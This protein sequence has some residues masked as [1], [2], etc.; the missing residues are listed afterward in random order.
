MITVKL[1][2]QNG[3]STG[4]LAKKIQAAAD[5]AGIEMT[6][7]AHSDSVIAKNILGADLVLIAPQIRFKL[8]DIQRDYPEYH[9]YT[10]DTFDYGMMNGESILKG[11]RKE[12]GI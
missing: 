5:K 7:S 12:L 4:M 8:P 6:V 1:F 9:Y 10:V 2:C 11:I 3:A